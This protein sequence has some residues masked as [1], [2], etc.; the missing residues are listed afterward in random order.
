MITEDENIETVKFHY[1]WIKY[2]SRFLYTQ[3]KHEYC[4]CFCE[5]C[6]H[7]YSRVDVLESHIPEC[8]GVGGTAFKVEMPEK[9]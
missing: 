7:G 5:R 2:L 1:I 8:K 6:L 3:S 9:G 4:E